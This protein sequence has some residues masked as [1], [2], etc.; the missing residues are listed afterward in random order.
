ML[1]RFHYTG[2]SLVY[3]ATSLRPYFFYFVSGAPPEGSPRKKMKTRMDSADGSDSP[4]ESRASAPA[5]SVSTTSRPTVLHAGPL[6]DGKGSLPR[7]GLAVLLALA[8]E[9]RVKLRGLCHINTTWT[10]RGPPTARA[11]GACD[12]TTSLLLGCAL[13][14]RQKTRPPWTSVA[15]AVLGAR[16]S[17]PLL[18]FF[19][20]LSRCS[21]VMSFFLAELLS[22]DAL[23]IDSRQREQGCTM[24]SFQCSGQRGAGWDIQ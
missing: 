12:R 22:Y 4:G 2:E 21:V 13:V 15:A 7:Y 5:S 14:L 1:G 18:S 6:S 11:C 24:G 20:F 3:T 8:G 16:P 23:A 10:V 19:S 17:P 9:K